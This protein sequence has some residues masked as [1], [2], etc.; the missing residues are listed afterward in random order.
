MIIN[1]K[2]ITKESLET[3]PV[4][5]TSRLPSSSQEIESNSMNV[6]SSTKANNYKVINEIRE[7]REEMVSLNENRS[8]NHTYESAA[9]TSNENRAIINADKKYSRNSSKNI[10]TDFKPFI[11]STLFISEK[12]ILETYNKENKDHFFKYNDFKSSVPVKQEL[13]YPS[14]FNKYPTYGQIHGVDEY[15]IP[16][17]SKFY[18]KEKFPIHATTYAP[19]KINP[20]QRPLLTYKNKKKYP[21]VNTNEEIWKTN[22]FL[23]G[24]RDKYPLNFDISSQFIDHEHFTDDYYNI[25]NKPLSK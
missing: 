11:P 16:P 7:H 18:E 21:F 23:H 15:E 25:F 8:D 1:D 24:H 14:N 19:S 20:M 4:I 17:Y 6:N 13:F 22:E 5:G 2:N 3:P 12:P 9:T 10:E